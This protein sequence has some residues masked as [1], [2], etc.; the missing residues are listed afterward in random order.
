MCSIGNCVHKPF[1]TLPKRSDGRKKNEEEEKNEENEEE[2]EEE[3]KKNEEVDD[4]D[5]DDDYDVD[6]YDVGDDDDDVDDY[7]VGELLKKTKRKP[8]T[9]IANQ[10]RK[11]SPSLGFRV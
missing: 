11:R 4:Y 3:E 1:G 10:R 7:D 2:E 8:A 9:K 5:D 6:D